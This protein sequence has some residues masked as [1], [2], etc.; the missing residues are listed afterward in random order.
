MNKKLL[1][2][3]LL[4]ITLMTVMSPTLFAQ[5]LTDFFTYYNEIKEEEQ[6]RI[7]EITNSP[8][9]EEWIGVVTENLP[10]DTMISTYPLCTNCD[11]FTVTVCA[12]ECTLLEEG[13]HSW[14]LGINK[15]YCYVHYYGSRGAEMC[16]TCYKILWIYD[17]HYCIQMHDTCSKGEYDI[18]PMSVS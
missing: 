16:P 1:L 18:C 13:Y 6:R 2:S 14:F 12:G 3:I 15:D 17:T 10:L 9:S 11:W 4:S 7:N 5:E 8:N